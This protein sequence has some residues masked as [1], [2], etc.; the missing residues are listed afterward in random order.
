MMESVMNFTLYDI[1]CFLLQAGK[2]EAT[3][4]LGM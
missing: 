2:L 3:D 1:S 4:R